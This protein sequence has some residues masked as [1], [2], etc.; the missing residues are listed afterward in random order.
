MLRT[1]GPL[2]MLFPL[3]AIAGV[4]GAP[5]PRSTG[6]TFERDVRPVLVRECHACHSGS[7]PSAGIALD[8]PLPERL[9][10]A[11]LVTALTRG[12]MPPSRALSAG[13]KAALIAWARS[14]AAWPAPSKRSPAP[15]WAFSPLSSN[16]FVGKPGSTDNPVDRIARV[17]L[18]RA[19]SVPL[20]SADRRTLI[21]RA[22]F[23]LTGLPPTVD[24]VESF[25]GDRRPG[26][27]NRVV[28]RLLSSRSHAE[29][30]GRRWLDVVRYADT[31]GENS[32]HPLPH[33]WRYRNW[34]ISSFEKN[35][36][37]DKFVKAQLA[38][39]IL[40]VGEIAGSRADGIVATGFLALARRFGHDIDQDIH[41]T[42][43]DA[44]DTTGKAFLGL[45][46]GCARCHDHK[47]DPIS[48]RDYT[49]LYGILASSR[50]SFP[51][52]EPKQQPRD[53]VPLREPSEV[54]AS[55]A[56]HRK[57]VQTKAA[58]AGRLARLE[59]D[60]L[61]PIARS[62]G[63]TTAVVASGSVVDG[64]PGI[65]A[66]GE[67]DVAV[68]SVLL[69]EV[70]PKANHGADTTRVAWSLSR[71]NGPPIASTLDLIDA[72]PSAAPALNLGTRGTW[73]F[74]DLANGPRLLA[75]KLGQIDGRT[76]LRGW[77]SGDTPSVF[78]NRALSAVDV[79]TRLAPRTLFV[80]PGPRGPVGL[81]WWSP[82]ADRIRFSLDIADAHPGG[83][84]V[85]W[86]ILKCDSVSSG[87]IER[88]AT[89]IV[90][91]PEATT[92]DPGPEPVAYA[93]VEG[94]A[95][96]ARI[97]RKGDPNDLGDRV[98]RGLP[99]TLGG[100]VV[101][102]TGSGREDLARELVRT[103]SSLLA[104][105]W[106]N[107]LWQLA[108]GSGLVSTPNDFGTR[109]TPPRSKVMLDMLATELIR[110]GWN[111]RTVLR[112]IFTS[113]T[114]RHAS[115]DTSKDPTGYA[116]HGRR[117]LDAE[118][119]R[120]TLLMV[121]GELDSTPGEAHPFPPENTWSF[122]QHTPF[123]AEYI[124][125][126]RAIYTMQKRNRRS[127]FTALFDG[128][129]PNASTAVRDTTTVPTQALWFLNNPEIESRAKAVG[130]IAAV[131]PESR[132]NDWLHRR[133]FGRPA[134]T[135][136]DADCRRFLSEAGPTSRGGAWTRWIRLL[137][138][139]NEFNHVD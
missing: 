69:L 80:H 11:R 97:Q 20:D 127:P 39:D 37:Y 36:P 72:L 75:E 62:L 128:P 33:A 117:R 4:S 45:G 111:T 78:A 3:V 61:A 1:F 23:D 68:G 41:L 26:A 9:G 46:L 81:A 90:T 99:R 18:R 113:E 121:S 115:G 109:G 130:E 5:P 63:D 110:T 106:A 51:G 59:S 56:L 48:Q 40:P 77:R 138:A 120:D 38:G 87:D 10:T 6:E 84:A 116:V 27:W 47:F 71:G 49:A 124:T 139:A 86:R 82:V 122:T 28:E 133:L 136:D 64:T 93:V 42:F 103:N 92:A 60:A 98:P 79:W 123:A 70:S 21:R 54:E 83:D 125:P 107:R 94:T 134:S 19:G 58:E 29:K 44:I 8:R 53:L 24:E 35:L 112:T 101:S 104:R 85:S 102:G 137:L 34:V 73:T 13:D 57:R 91:L 16:P 95:A 15:H 2:T 74:L 129:D 108:F 132:R 105:V 52:C 66:T 114:Y 17:E 65:H 43:E 14:G 135:Q 32:D 89:G 131:V 67:V 30:L 50:F 7:R 100:A 76:E 31:A 126:R 55:R 119:L 118:E 88:V 12:A 25:L 22:T 96:D